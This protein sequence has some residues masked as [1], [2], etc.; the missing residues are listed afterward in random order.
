MTCSGYPKT[1]SFSTIFSEGFKFES[2]DDNPIIETKFCDNIHVLLV[3]WTL[4]YLKISQYHKFVK[5]STKINSQTANNVVK[6]Q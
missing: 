5:Y 1:F 2:I 4:F 6:G 3:E